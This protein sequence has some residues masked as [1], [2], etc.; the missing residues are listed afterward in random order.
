MINN[1]IKI[2]CRNDKIADTNHVLL[3]ISKYNGLAIIQNNY[4]KIDFDLTPQRPSTL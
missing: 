2:D 1:I 4:N 3:F